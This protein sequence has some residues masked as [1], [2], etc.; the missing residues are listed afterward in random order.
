MHNS[1][2]QV[3]NDSQFEVSASVLEGSTSNT[4]LS[5]VGI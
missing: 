1:I 5:P 3:K 2:T 4:P